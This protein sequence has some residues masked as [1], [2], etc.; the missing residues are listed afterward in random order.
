MNEK[1]KQFV[2]AFTVSKNL[3]EAIL[4]ILG[5]ED[6]KGHAEAWEITVDECREA[7]VSIV[8]HYE[9]KYGVFGLLLKADLAEFYK[10]SETAKKIVTNKGDLK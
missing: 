7:I 9:G 8:D 5:E 4:D 1:Q 2:G 10:M 6:I 3:A